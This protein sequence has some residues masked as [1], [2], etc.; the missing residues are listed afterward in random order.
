MT[1]HSQPLSIRAKVSLILSVWLIVLA[2][3]IHSLMVYAYTAGPAAAAP[4]SWI[5]ERGAF[6]GGDTSLLVMFVHPHCPCSRASVSE[7]AVLM[8]MANGALKARVYFYVPA[9]MG[10]G[11]ERTALW[12]AA[13]AIP[14]VEPLVDRDGRAARAFDAQVSGD[15]QVYGPDRLLAFSGGITP[16]RG[17]EGDSEGRRA[18]IAHLSRVP[19]PVRHTPAFGCYLFGSSSASE[20]QS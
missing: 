15:T 2:L 11:W 19:T 5:A 3:G 12:H 17:H 9:G 1:A 13:A 14:G 20:P 4:A 10:D 8:A 16:A 6:P 7:L 18:I